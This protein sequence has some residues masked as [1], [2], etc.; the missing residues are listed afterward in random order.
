MPHVVCIGSAVADLV[1]RGVERMPARGDRDFVDS[2][3]LFPGGNAVNV[4]IDLK[5]LAGDALR[6]TCI[7]PI[8]ADPFGRF[9]REE[10]ARAGVEFP[11]AHD[12]PA[13]AAPTAVSIVLLDPRGEAH[14]IQA[15]HGQ[16][17]FNLTHIRSAASCLETADWLHF[18]G[19]GC[20]PGLEGRTRAQTTGDPSRGVE[21]LAA[22]LR[23]VRLARPKLI[24]SADICQVRAH[25][26]REW[27]AN[28]GPLLREIDFF[29]PNHEEA[30]HLLLDRGDDTPLDAPLA[31]RRLLAELMGPGARAAF[32]KCAES[33]V[34]WCEP[35]AGHPAHA[36]AFPAAKRDSTGAGDSW[37]AGF[38][39]ALLRGSPLPDAA[40]FANAVAAHCVEH[41]GATHGVPEAKTVLARMHAP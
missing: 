8:G 9:M 31:A 38:I 27:Q 11:F 20:L 13:S 21:P 23:Q 2:A 12:H 34:V 19:F 26:R 5:R 37:C 41:E 22:W 1:V 3:S 25:H 6:V 36:P 29:M 40:R 16:E 18:A 30:R 32:V 35:G 33:G 4:A 17:A 10:L 15:P 7:A 14:F 24:T 39:H 28:I